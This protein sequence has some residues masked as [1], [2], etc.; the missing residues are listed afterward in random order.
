M[1]LL[2]QE[3]VLA[4]KQ[5]IATQTRKAEELNI[6]ADMNLLYFA[7]PWV[8]FVPLGVS[9]TLY[10]NKRSLQATVSGK[11]GSERQPKKRKHKCFLIRLLGP[12]S[13]PQGGQDEPWKRE[14]RKEYVTQMSP[15]A[16]NL[17]SQKRDWIL[18]V[19]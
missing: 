1:L 10:S 19:P 5:Q 2:I 12:G 3:F 15:L 4:W 9:P 13:S 8:C 11:L 6:L 18:S 17:L 16:H 14:E 7:K